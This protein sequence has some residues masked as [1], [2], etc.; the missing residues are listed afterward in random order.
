ME[1]GEVDRQ[2]HRLDHVQ[3]RLGHVLHGYTHSPQTVALF[4]AL[5]LDPRRRRLAAARARLATR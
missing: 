2:E 1:K 5:G 4:A 3:R